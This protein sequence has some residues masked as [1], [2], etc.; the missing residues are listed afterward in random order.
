MT[1]QKFIKQVAE[2]ISRAT[3]PEAAAKR[4]YEVCC[5]AAEAW[6]LNPSMEVG[7]RAPG[8]PRHH[9]DIGCWAVSFEAGP[10]EWAIAASLNLDTKGK[11]LAEPYYSFDLCF[12]EA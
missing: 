4:T 9:S 10:Y 5:K 3:D 2:V 8:E 12:T 11:V 6:G 1:E 7:I